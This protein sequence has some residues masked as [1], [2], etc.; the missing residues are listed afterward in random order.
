MI[1]PFGYQTVNNNG[2][3]EIALDPI[4]KE[5]IKLCFEMY[6]SNEFPTEAISQEIKKRFDLSISK[7]KLAEIIRN[8]FY[9]GILQLPDKEIYHSFETIISPEIQER[10]IYLLVNR[11]NHWRTKGP[12]NKAKGMWNKTPK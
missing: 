1:Y 10:A 9:S 4:K 7:I 2:V 3:I 12:K 11:N 8:K 5:A 6:I